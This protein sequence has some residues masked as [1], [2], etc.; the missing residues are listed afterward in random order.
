MMLRKLDIQMQT[1][2]L[3]PYLAMYTQINPKW[4]KHLNI[5]ETFECF[6]ISCRRTGQQWPSTGTRSLAA[7]EL[8]GTA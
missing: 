5:S 4:V 7:A 2:K 6:S 3:Y 8:G 1:M